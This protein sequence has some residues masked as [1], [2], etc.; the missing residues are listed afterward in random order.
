MIELN[1]MVL[2]AVKMIHMI[3][4]MKNGIITIYNK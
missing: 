2:E 3:V 4:T 1:N